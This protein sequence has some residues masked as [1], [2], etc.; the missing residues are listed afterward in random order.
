MKTSLGMHATLKFITAYGEINV[1]MLSH[2]VGV[3]L[4]LL[5]TIYL[6]K[7]VD[8]ID[9]NLGPTSVRLHL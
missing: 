5:Y 1:F 9:Q 3:T 2:R 6:G 7:G 4:F 8:N